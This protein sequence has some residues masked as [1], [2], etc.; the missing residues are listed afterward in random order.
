MA[1]ELH[2]AHGYGDRGCRGDLEEEIPK[3]GRRVPKL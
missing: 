1:P 2:A 3:I